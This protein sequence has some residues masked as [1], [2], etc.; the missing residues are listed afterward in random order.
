[1]TL[2]L[3]IPKVQVVNF[4]T[5]DK[6]DKIQM[7]VTILSLFVALI[8]LI[9]ASISTYLFIN[10]VS[11]HPDVY[12]SVDSPTPILGKIIFR[13]EDNAK[14]SNNLEFHVELKNKGDKNSEALNNVFIMFDKSVK[15]EILS[16][17]FWAEKS[18]GSY[19]AYSYQKPDIVVI[20]DTLKHIG[21]FKISIPRQSERLLLATFHIEGD[22][23]KRS[24]LIYYDFEKQEY[25]INH[26]INHGEVIAI[27]NAHLDN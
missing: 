26:S 14:Y 5:K 1:M 4:P 24:G 23:E 18:L 6:W 19:K 22:F 8:S 2:N 15:V 13:F 16:K 25:I 17:A 21:N 27:W 12:L 11:K 3:R 20:K 7:L 10:E 9:V